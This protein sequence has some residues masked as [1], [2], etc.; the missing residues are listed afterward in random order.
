MGTQARE[1]EEEGGSLGQLD[2]SS[3]QLVQVPD[4]IYHLLRET[5]LT[6]CD[7]S[8]NAITKVPPKLAKTFSLITDLNI[9]TNKISMLPTELS[10]CT[11]L[12]RLNISSNFFDT[13]PPVLLD[14]PSL[15]ELD[16]GKN[17]IAEVELD[18]LKTSLPA[19]QSLNLE[20]N[21]LK[22][23]TYEALLE[24]KSCKV[25][26]SPREEWEDLLL[27]PPQAPHAPQAPSTPSRPLKSP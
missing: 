11:S 8:S 7:L 12:E 19:L 5:K 6:K 3:C 18:G 4:A 9:S 22:K 21:P 2:L 15:V 10:A 16:A 20:K 27:N 23:E 26:V 17:S 24:V 14:I 25:V 13:L 1:G